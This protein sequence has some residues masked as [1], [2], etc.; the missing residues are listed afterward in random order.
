[1]MDLK[2]QLTDEGKQ[3]MLNIYH[4]DVDEPHEAPYKTD[5]N[6]SKTMILT[7]LDDEQ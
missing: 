5:P 7:N 1:M 4:A 6:D 2:T 3:G